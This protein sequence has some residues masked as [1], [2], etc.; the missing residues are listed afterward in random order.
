MR[1]E[2]DFS[3]AKLN[4]YI[5]KLRKQISIRIDIDTIEYFK[6]QA[7]DTGI[8]YQNLINLYLSNCASHK[9]TVNIEWK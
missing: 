2:Y 4:P 3:K 7:H 6:R 5:K 1:K 9:K 8:S